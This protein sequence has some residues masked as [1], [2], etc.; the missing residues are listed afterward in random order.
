MSEGWR[1]EG[2]SDGYGL[3]GV[4]GVTIPESCDTDE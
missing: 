4:S 1:D 3:R 2:Y